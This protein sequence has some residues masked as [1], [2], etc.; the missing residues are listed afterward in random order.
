MLLTL[1]PTNQLSETMMRKLLP[2]AALAALA[3][4][5]AY[6]GDTLTFEGVAN[7]TAVGNFYSG[8]SFSGSIIGL[9]DSDAGGTGDIANE[10]SGN[11]VIYF[12]DGTTPLIS[13]GDGFSDAFT[14]YYASFLGASVNIYDD[15]FGVGNLLG[16]VTLPAQYADNNCV[17]D[18]TGNVCNYTQVSISFS[19]VARSVTFG[20]TANQTSF[21]NLTFGAADVGAVP[22][23]GT[24][25]MLLLGFGAVGFGLRRRR[26]S[27][28]FRT[29]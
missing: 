27:P 13:V 5:P 7:N 16:T 3:A 6:A 19:G 23:P 24:W 12:T 2:L 25:A 21:D 26:I 29:A 11:T 15:L 4:S 28:A 20:G 22:E 1:P 8:Y 17:G 10:P 14:F 18:P 9:I